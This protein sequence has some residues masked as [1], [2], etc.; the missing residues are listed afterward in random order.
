M[1]A[2]STLPPTTQRTSPPSDYVDKF[3]SLLSRSYLT[4][5]LTTAFISEIDQ[6]PSGSKT[7]IT[8]ERLHKHFSL[9]IPIAAKANVILIEASNFAAAAFV[10]PPDFHG[11]PPAQARRQPG[12]IL[13]E[14]R[15]MARTLKGKYLSIPDS[16]PRSY[17]Q[18]AAP[19]QG[20]GGPGEDPYPG[21][22]NKDVD[23][24][25][26]P[27]Y[28]LALMARDPDVDQAKS[29]AAMK[30]CLQPFLDKA[31]AEGVPVWLETATEEMRDYYQSLG[32]K[33]VE[34]VVIGKGRV[35]SKGWP[36]QGGEGVR[37][38]PMMLDE[39]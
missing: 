14:W 28:H 3:I 23:H 29:D 24:E 1:S 4:T 38:W 20:S 8:S 19:S 31:K 17:D 6:V 30:A 12:P 34:E 2:A 37:C 25:T 21:D 32:F 13:V 15:G 27:F 5:P 18:P 39:N 36:K 35:D 9:G 7:Q 33:V 10:E 11:T 22:F 26:R 16:G